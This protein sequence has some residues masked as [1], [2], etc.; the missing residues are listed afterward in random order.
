MLNCYAAGPPTVSRVITVS[1]GLPQSFVS[2]IFQ[3]DNGFLW[4]ATLNGLGRYDGKQFK[5]YLHTAADATGLSG[6]I[7]LHLFDAGNKNVLVCYLDGKIDELNTVTEKVT[8]LWAN[9]SFQILTNETAYFK[10]LVHDSKGICWMMSRDGGL[11]RI[12]PE[13]QQVMHLSPAQLNCKGPVLGIA[14]YGD[15]LLLFTQ[16]SM[17][18]SNTGNRPTKT[19]AYP[20]TLNKYAESNTTIYSPGVRPNGDLLLTDAEGLKIWNPFSGF[21]K[22]IALKRPKSP[23]K[24]I[25]AFDRG[26]NYYFEYR[27][28][29]YVLRTN[30]ELAPWLPA[31]VTKSVLTSMYA[32]KSG[33]LWVGTN[34]FGLRQYNLLQTGMPGYNYSRSFVYDVLAHYVNRKAQLSGTFVAGSIPYANRTAVYGDSVWV[35]DANLRQVKPQLALVEN[36][37]IKVQSFANSN[38]Q[39][40]TEKRGLQ[41]I[42]CTGKGVL[43]GIDQNYQLMRFDTRKQTFH[44]FAKTGIATGE[45][46]NGMVA[47]NERAFYI[48][49]NK[50]LL[51][52]DAFTGT[53]ENLTSAL[54][55]SY[56]FCIS[57]DRKNS[58]ILWIGTMSDGLI[59]FNKSAKTV[60]VFSLM[61]GLPNNTVYGILA[62]RTGVLW[63][64]SNKGIYAFDTGS[65]TVHSFTSKDGLPVDEFNRYHYLELPNG[66]MAFGGSSGYTIFNP[67]KF[68]T[69]TFDPQIVIT[70]LNVINRPPINVPL[71]GLQ[72]IDL[73]YDQNFLTLTFAVMQFDFPEKNQYRY[74]LKGLDKNWVMPGNENKASYTSLPPGNY[75]LLLNAT[76]TSGKWSRYYRKVQ[77]IIAPPFWLT[78]WFYVM[79]I[80][81]LIVLIYGIIT[82]RV[83]G[84]KRVQ[85][86]KLHFERQAIELQA[87]ALRSRMNPHFIFNC[88]NSIKALIQEK[89]TKK[90]ITYLT[91][92][93]A[94][95]RKQLHNTGNAVLLR[96]ELETCRL[97]L[98]LENMRFEGRIAYQFIVRNEQLTEISVPPLILQPV[99]ENA[100]VHGLLPGWHGGR[101]DIRVYR[102]GAFV[103]CEI[104]DNGIGRAASAIYKQNSSRLHQSKGIHLLEERLS[105][106][107]QINEQMDSLEIIDLYND[108]KAGGTLV[109]MKFNADI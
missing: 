31:T 15:Q 48:S 36:G 70:D 58:G 30:N 44:L 103:V 104:E 96:D 49:T 52:I 84:I 16:T 40:N 86:Q 26:G 35:I 108:G 53:T 10:S 89:D 109:I 41:F 80:L 94:L 43:W 95:I 24:L 4:V 78:W 34:G 99:I 61:T 102:D 83:R 67:A 65:Q 50:S 38:K 2:G 106:H 74:R 8:R 81:A 21:F 27:L 7:I 13:L 75:T 90:A 79:V 6:N 5:Q 42:C 73:R 93:A 39:V 62:D 47:D 71:N 100:I 72:K 17:V 29:I 87:V 59:R 20:F 23:S 88:L 57:N 98:E 60:Q 68:S 14:V 33:V 12:D 63:C 69:D 11:F 51:K 76:N 91:T 32:D 46:I 85:A 107:N 22:S 45:E 97:Y 77:I 55:G 92:F 9:K 3:D 101:I 1:D 64:S 28:G 82:I 105:V 19:I 54:P 56:L 66:D 37:N 25:A 18:I